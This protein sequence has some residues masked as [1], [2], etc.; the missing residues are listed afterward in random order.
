MI[1]AIPDFSVP[2]M[3]RLWE[4]LAP[5]YKE[6]SIVLPFDE[7][8]ADVF[9]STRRRLFS[10]LEGNLDF[11]LNFPTKGFDEAYQFFA[12]VSCIAS[13]NE[14][15]KRSFQQLFYK[16]MREE[17]EDKG[18][19]FEQVPFKIYLYWCNKINQQNWKWKCFSRQR[20]I[21]SELTAHFDNKNA[22]GPSFTLMSHLMTWY[23]HTEGPSPRNVYWN[24]QLSVL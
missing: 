10:D 7:K 20:C 11:R 2:W 18:V 23:S 4:F 6:K 22:T 13:A 5:L 9:S 24:A 17:F 3:A 1:W 15:T 19:N 16:V 8:W 21:C 12:S 14:S